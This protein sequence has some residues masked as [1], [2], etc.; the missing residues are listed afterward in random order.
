MIHGVTVHHLLRSCRVGNIMR[1]PSLLVI[2]VAALPLCAQTVPDEV[3]LENPQVRVVQMTVNPH[4]QSAIRTHKT[5]RVMIYRDGGHVQI[6]GGD[7]RIE[8]LDVPE[9]DARWSRAGEP[10]I[11]ENLTDHPIRI[12]EIELKAGAGGHAAVSKMD[13]AAVDSRHYNMEFEN[14]QVRVLRVHFG[15]HEKGVLH[16][17]VLDRVVVYLTDQASTKAGS[18]RMAGAATHTEENAGD[19]PAELI[20]VELK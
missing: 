5:N 14:D 11:M 12:V 20:A 4:S 15:A 19:E 9:G 8:D 6:S 10:Y 2:V 18:V 1:S 13:P 7:G 17:H 16:E 3:K